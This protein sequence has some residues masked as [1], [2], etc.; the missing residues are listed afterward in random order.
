MASLGLRLGGRAMRQAAKTSTGI[1]G[2]L[3][4]RLAAP[5]LASSCHRNPPTPQFRC[6]GGFG[7][8][9]WLLFHMAHVGL[10]RWSR[11]PATC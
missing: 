4:W 5:C 7:H 8:V 10:S 11:R 1:V 2:L 9:Y 3:V 6:M